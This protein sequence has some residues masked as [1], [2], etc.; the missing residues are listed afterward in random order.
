VSSF[1]PQDRFCQIRGLGEIYE[2]FLGRKTSGTF[3]EVGA[4]DG[5]YVSNSWGL[6]ERGW[7]GLMV[8][9]LPDLAKRCR[10]NHKDHPAVS[11][12]EAAVAG[13]GLDEVTL[14][15]AGALTTA[16]DAVHNAYKG[17]DWAKGELSGDSLRV[18]ALTLDNLLVQEAIPTEFDVLIVDVEGFEEEVFAGFDLNRWRP[19]L[20]IVELTDSHPNLRERAA[21]DCRLGD[22][23]LHSGY[24]IVYKDIANTVFVRDDIRWAAMPDEE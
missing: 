13:P 6:A 17:L 10:E 19:S 22:Q 20:M 9:P 12:V 24:G 16:N 4:N 7:V 5:V 15:V 1:Y 14:F 8:E 2:L 11:V 3:V 23:I 18:R 21:A